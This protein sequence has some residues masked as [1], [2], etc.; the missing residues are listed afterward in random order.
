MHATRDTQILNSSI[1]NEFTFKI[2]ANT[3]RS[4]VFYKM[5]IYLG[6]V[7]NIYRRQNIFMKIVLFA[8]ERNTQ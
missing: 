5:I 2:L 4:V 8:F 7:Q 3:D 6:A 1:Q